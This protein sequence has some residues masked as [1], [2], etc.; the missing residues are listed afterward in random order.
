MTCKRNGRRRPGGAQNE[1]ERKDGAGKTAGKKV[2]VV[3]TL[4]FFVR[5]SR[6][7]EKKEPRKNR[8]PW[9]AQKR[10]LAAAGQVEI[11]GS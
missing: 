2:L 8:G 5:N 3:E 7:R 1:E 9:R 6:V 11:S 4:L 10:R